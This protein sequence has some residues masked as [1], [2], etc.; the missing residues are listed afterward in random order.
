MNLNVG[1]VGNSRQWE[2]LLAQEGVPFAPLKGPAV[3]AEYS[4][5]V[6]GDDVHDHDLPVGGEIHLVDSVHVGVD[7]HGALRRDRDGSRVERRGP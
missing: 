6:A 4:A 3:P 2:A 1:I 5:I 7:E